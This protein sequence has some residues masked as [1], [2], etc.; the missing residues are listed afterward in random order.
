MNT[1]NLILIDSVSA[2]QVR[3]TPSLMNVGSLSVRKLFHDLF[4]LKRCIVSNTSCSSGLKRLHRPVR[5]K[6]KVKLTL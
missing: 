3:P 5:T 2:A 1:G 4:Q 6:N